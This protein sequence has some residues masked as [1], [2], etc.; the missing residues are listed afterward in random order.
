[1][2]NKKHRTNLRKRVIVSALAGIV[3]M[4]AV[5]A[6]TLQTQASSYDELYELSSSY[7]EIAPDC[8]VPVTFTEYLNMLKMVMSEA[9][10]T[11]KEVMSGCASTAI[12][13]SI[14]YELS[15]QET[16]DRPDAFRNGVYEFVD[17]EGIQREVELSD[18]NSTVIDATN[19]ALKG[20]DVTSEIG[21]AIGFYAPNICSEEMAKYMY[22]H[23]SDGETM[24]IENVVFFSEWK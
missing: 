19:D 12:N 21:G 6:T 17:S 22:D 23:T 14:S 15:M 20:N 8:V 24:Q 18:I 16:L 4:V 11:S 2:E 9:G 3:G 1:M 10:A 5:N 13:Q 7:K